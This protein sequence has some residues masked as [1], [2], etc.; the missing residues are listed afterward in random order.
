MKI[1]DA[2]SLIAFLWELDY[3]EGLR[4]LSLRHRIVVPS[5]VV[6]E[7]TRDR[8][9]ASLRALLAAGVIAEQAITESEV[10]KIRALHPQLGRGECEVLA[11]AENT[12]SKE[13]PVLVCDDKVA[14][15]KFPNLR[16][17]WT[18]ELL[19]YMQRRGLIEEGQH[20]VLLE[21][22]AKSTFYSRVKLHEP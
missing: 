19:D 8:S 22:L 15:S 5:G 20:K 7:V 13:P 2:T 10:E 6:S 18:E 9:R 17:V 11:I 4:L 16:F 3:P 21:R 1:F 12:D 14:R